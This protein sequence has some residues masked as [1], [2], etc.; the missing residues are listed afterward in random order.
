MTIQLTIEE[1]AKLRLCSD[2]V[3]EYSLSAQIERLGA[4]N[5]C[6]YC[7]RSGNT[8]SIA[9][10]ANEVAI[11][12]RDHY[13]LTRSEPDLIE[14][15]MTADEEMNY[16]WQR[17]GVPVTD[18]IVESAEVTEEVA[19]DIRGVLEDRELSEWFGSFEN[20]FSSEA[21]YDVKDADDTEHRESWLRLEESLTTEARFFNP[22]AE[23]ILTDTFSDID[24]HR[25]HSG[26]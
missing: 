14:Y 17:E 4:E 2:C 13:D 19:E 15:H 10:V 6:S 8:Y 26:C 5:V 20:P 25:T 18:V 9:Q 16:E 7:R 23:A 22:T 3:G 11:A 12:F 21:Y 1:V 24:K